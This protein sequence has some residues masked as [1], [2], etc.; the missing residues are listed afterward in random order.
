MTTPTLREKWREFGRQ[1]IQ[2]D[3]P[4]ECVGCTADL[5][6]MFGFFLSQFSAEIE[7][8]RKTVICPRHDLALEA[9]CEC[10]PD[11]NAAL[12]ELKRRMTI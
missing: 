3:H 9:A 10:N 11:W 6:A 8:L 2:G 7:G 12:D 1:F 4:K 5:D